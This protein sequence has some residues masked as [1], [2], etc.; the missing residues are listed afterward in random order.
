MMWWTRD[1]IRPPLVACAL[2]TDGG[3]KQS[4]I[5]RDKSLHALEKHKQI[6][7]NYIQL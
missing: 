6:K 3:H 7:H 1:I 5:G 4:A 2:R